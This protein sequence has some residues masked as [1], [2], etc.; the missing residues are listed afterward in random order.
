MFKSAMTNYGKKKS[1]YI[2]KMLEH[3]DEHT[4]KQ[5]R[6][7]KQFTLGNLQIKKDLSSTKLIEPEISR[8]AKVRTDPNVT[9][10]HKQ[11]KSDQQLLKQQNTIDF[12]TV[13]RNIK[14]D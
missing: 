6:V 4:M 3:Y 2:A 7:F 13:V 9:I 1:N 11:D 12:N 14:K 5:N 10:E 8:A